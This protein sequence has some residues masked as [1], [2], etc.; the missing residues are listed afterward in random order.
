MTSTAYAFLVANDT[1]IELPIRPTYEARRLCA[2]FHR[3]RANL[4]FA[5]ANL[6]ATGNLGSIE[7][8]AESFEQLTKAFPEPKTSCLVEV[9]VSGSGCV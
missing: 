3:G 1:R 5:C 7:T 4:G 8:R 6:G 9:I 2:H